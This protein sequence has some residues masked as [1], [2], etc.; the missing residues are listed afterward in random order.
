MLL[1]NTNLLEGNVLMFH[2]LHVVLLSLSVHYSVNN[3]THA[4][5][6]HTGPREARYRSVICSRSLCVY[7]AQ[8]HA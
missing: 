3:D 5:E 4:G 2:D 7:H 8:F 6:H 1:D